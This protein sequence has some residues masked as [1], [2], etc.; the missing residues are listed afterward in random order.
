MISWTA[1]V[2]DLKS[3]NPYLIFLRLHIYIDLSWDRRRGFV[4]DSELQSKT[5][6]IHTNEH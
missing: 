3:M 2:S 4:T 5:M 6:T 1:R